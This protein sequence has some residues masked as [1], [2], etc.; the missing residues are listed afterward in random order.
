LLLSN[1]SSI[2][3][4]R[5]FSVSRLKCHPAPKIGAQKLASSLLG[6]GLGVKESIRRMALYNLECDSTNWLQFDVRLYLL[7]K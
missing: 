4:V 1:L 7:R 2:N 6:I 3:T 5:T